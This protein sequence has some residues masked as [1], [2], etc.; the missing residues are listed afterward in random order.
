MLVGDMFLNKRRGLEKFLARFASELAF[1]FL[2]D[3]RFHSF[4]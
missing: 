1:I 3:E 4:S 2:L